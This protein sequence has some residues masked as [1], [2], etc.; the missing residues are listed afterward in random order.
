MTESAALAGRVVFATVTSQGY[1]DQTAGL[2]VNLHQMH[3]DCPLVVC[4]LDDAGATAF[5]GRPGG[6]VMVRA[7]DAWGARHWANLR[8]RTNR[9]ESAYASK[10]AIAVHVL[11]QD[12]AAVI[13]LD[14]DLLF[15]EPVAD[16]IDRATRTDVLL[17]AARHDLA[18]WRKSDTYGVYSAGIVGFAQSGRRAAAIW[19]ALCFDET[20]AL[21][22]DGLFN[23]QKYLDYLPGFF[24][25]DVIRDP[26]VNV[27]ATVLA[28][29]AP[30]RDEAGRYRTA[31]GHPI[32]VFH[33]STTTDKSLE[34]A[35][36]KLDLNASAMTRLGIDV[37]DVRTADAA[38][39]PAASSRK[40]FPA[41]RRALNPGRASQRPAEAYG[42]GLRHVLTLLRVGQALGIGGLIG[43]GAIA[44]EKAAL[45]AELD[46]AA[47]PAK[48]D[49]ATTGPHD[50]GQD[51]LKSGDRG[52]ATSL[53]GNPKHLYSETWPNGQTVSTGRHDATGPPSSTRSS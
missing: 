19:K 21:A 28:R 12:A 32:R 51:R 14:S 18:T 4:A 1:I 40:R 13:V 17:T 22:A 16:L 35:R 53:H 3:P 50:T 43:Y 39:A 38:A 6:A 41:L 36:M 49:A 7:E 24:A 2:A 45:R 30:K 25:T 11:A 20:R 29:H 44:R 42:A 9:R 34:L 27:S 23:E 46:R 48:P 26:G 33:C 5:A 47:D 37:P 15:I 10:S 8:L 31:D 52:T